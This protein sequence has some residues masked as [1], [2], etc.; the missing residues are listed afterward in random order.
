MRTTC[1]III[2]SFLALPASA[3][4]PAPKRQPTNAQQIREAPL[5]VEPF[6]LVQD[7]LPRGYR[8]HNCSAIAK[9]LQAITSMEGR[10]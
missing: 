5:A 7:K 6:D 10:V 3:Q 1:T 8:G 9:A 2:V 4:S